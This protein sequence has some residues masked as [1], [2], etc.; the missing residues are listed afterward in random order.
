MMVGIINLS[1]DPH[2]EKL[3][4]FVYH[5]DT[6]KKENGS[7]RVQGYVKVKDLLQIDANDYPGELRIGNCETGVKD[8]ELVIMI[9]TL[10]VWQSMHSL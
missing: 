5:T 6:Y 8:G 2:L 4:S 7:F 10:G 1:N 3:L 9:W